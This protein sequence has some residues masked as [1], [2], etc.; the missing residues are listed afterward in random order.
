MQQN[1]RR[2]FY[3]TQKSTFHDEITVAANFKSHVATYSMTRPILKHFA[4]I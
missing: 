3:G 2:L 4:S 1:V